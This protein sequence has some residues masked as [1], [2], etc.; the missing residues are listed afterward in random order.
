CTNLPLS[1]GVLKRYLHS[2]TGSGAVSITAS[3]EPG[4]GYGYGYRYGYGYGYEPGVGYGYGYY[5]F[6]YGFGYG[7]GYS[8]YVGATS[9]TYSGSW[10]SPSGWPEGGYKIEVRVTANDTYFTQTSDEFTLSAPPVGVGFIGTIAPPAPPAAPGATD[11]SDLVTAAGVF[12]QDVTAE[13]E[14]GK[15]ALT[16]E[17]GT[18]GLTEEG[19]PLSE[20]SITEV[21]DPPPPPADASIVGLTYELGPDGATFDPPITLTFTYDPDEIPAGVSE[22][23]LVIAIWDADAGVWIELEGCTVDP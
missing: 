2:D 10:T 4:W 6:G 1:H 23:D 12:T 21:E 18:I 11:V 14:D 16:I 5:D 17:E 20:I 15:V 7:Y 9:I 22:E 3:T 8:P 13:S 19:E